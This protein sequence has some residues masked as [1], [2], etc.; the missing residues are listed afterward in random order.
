M[1]PGG[2]FPANPDLADISGRTEFDFE[3]FRFLDFFNSQLALLAWPRLGTSAKLNQCR[4]VPCHGFTCHVWPCKQYVMPYVSVSFHVMFIPRRSGS[5]VWPTGP[6]RKIY[7]GSGPGS[8]G[9]FFGFFIFF[10][11]LFLSLCVIFGFWCHPEIGTA[12]TK[13]F[14]LLESENMFWM[15]ANCIL[16]HPLCS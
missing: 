7:S 14:E 11:K 13:C 10:G 2:V 15:P 16:N 9:H 3:N 6:F 4:A 12:M 8:V 1:G 5:R